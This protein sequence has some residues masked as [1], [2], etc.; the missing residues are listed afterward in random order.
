MHVIAGFLLIHV[1]TGF[2]L[3]HVII[4]FRLVIT[5]FLLTKWH[6]ITRVLLLYIIPVITGFLLIHVKTRF[7]LIHVI[8]GFLLLHVKTGSQLIHVIIGFLLIHVKTGFLLIYVI[9]DSN[10]TDLEVLIHTSILV[11]H[12]DILICFVFFKLLTSVRV[13]SG[14]KL[15]NLPI[16]KWTISIRKAEI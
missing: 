6:V 7:Q 1:I 8:I 5:G 4:R 9:S 16:T 11:S 14:W 13:R 12:F 2:L 10:C 3:I 15:Y